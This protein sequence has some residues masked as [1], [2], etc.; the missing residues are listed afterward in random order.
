M[1][2]PPKFM[3]MHGPLWS[4]VNSHI[5]E[6]DLD[7]PFR[8][9]WFA[10]TFCSTVSV[11]DQHSI[12][13]RT[14]YAL[15]SHYG[16]VQNLSTSDFHVPEPQTGAD[17][18]LVAWSC[19]GWY[20]P[21]RR[22]I[23]HMRFPPYTML[24]PLFFKKASLACP[25]V[26]CEHLKHCSLAWHLMIFVQTDGSSLNIDFACVLDLLMAV[27][28]WNTHTVIRSCGIQIRKITICWWF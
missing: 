6:L 19:A 11:S 21:A 4:S 1:F 16:H 12:L 26:T 15:S 28:V 8:S 5:V 14:V 24:L 10:Q 18:D 27:P 2:I 3:D 20:L 7:V 23:P 25:Q 13:P 22:Q 9:S 17:T